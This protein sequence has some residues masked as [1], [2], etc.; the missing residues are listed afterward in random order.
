MLALPACRSCRKARAVFD[1]SFAKLKKAGIAYF[2]DPHKAGP[3]EIN[4]HWGGRGVYFEDPNGHLLELIDIVE[5]GLGTAVALLE[6]GF[7][8]AADAGDFGRWRQRS[9]WGEAV[10]EG[11]AQALLVA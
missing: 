1:A 5:A 7:A 2:A 6:D 8:E 11:F 3:G 10:G 4:H 9:A